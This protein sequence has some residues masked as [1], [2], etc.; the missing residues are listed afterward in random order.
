M[1]MIAAMR[2][3]ERAFAR[4]LMKSRFLAALAAHVAQPVPNFHDAVQANVIVR[5]LG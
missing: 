1:N 3:T 4:K 2:A 5:K